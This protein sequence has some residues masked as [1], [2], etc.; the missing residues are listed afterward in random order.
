MAKNPEKMDP[1][2]HSYKMQ[3]S[4]EDLKD[5]RINPCLVQKR[6]H[7]SLS[8]PKEISLPST[9]NYIRKSGSLAAEIYNNVER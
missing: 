7:N 3:P 1:K 4:Q 5:S 9:S 8:L 6:N 2:L